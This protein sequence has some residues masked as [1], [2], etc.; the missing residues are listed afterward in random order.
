MKTLRGV[1]VSVEAGTVA[2][3]P[4][5]PALLRA[6]AWQ[7]IDRVDPTLV[8]LVQRV[9]ALRRFRGIEVRLPG[10]ETAWIRWRVWSSENAA[11]LT[12]L[13]QATEAL[14]VPAYEPDG[15]YFLACRA[16]ALLGGKVLDP[17][18]S[19]PALGEESY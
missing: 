14:A 1:I 10:G 11:A 6:E 19:V 4:S 13:R 7:P 3:V 9:P 8:E 2:R 12:R 16:V 18:R 15:D 17:P 5:V